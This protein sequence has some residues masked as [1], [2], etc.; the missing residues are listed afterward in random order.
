MFELSL[1]TPV[2][3]HLGKCETL[4]ASSCTSSGSK[5]DRTWYPGKF[6]THF[7]SSGSDLPPYFALSILQTA[8][9]SRYED[10]RRIELRRRS[11]TLLAG[12]K[13]SRSPPAPASVRPSRCP[14]VR[15]RRRRE[16]YKGR[17]RNGDD[18]TV[19]FRVRSLVHPCL[20]RGEQQTRSEISSR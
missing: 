15:L 2:C 13:I 16:G 19:G 20:V 5:S 11:G 3:E 12:G 8:D 14:P 10:G 1:R 7:S 6:C 4:N 9:W 18:F 17:G